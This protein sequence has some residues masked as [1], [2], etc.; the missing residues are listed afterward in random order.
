MIQ[1]LKNGLNDIILSSDTDFSVLAK[2]IFLISSSLIGMEVGN[3]MKPRD[4]HYSFG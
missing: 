1:Q 3:C 2:N 4:S